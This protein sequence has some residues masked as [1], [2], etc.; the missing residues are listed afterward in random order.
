MF[1]LFKCV[2]ISVPK[3]RY[4]QTKVRRPIVGLPLVMGLPFEK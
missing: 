1:Y 2:E 3:I 4:P